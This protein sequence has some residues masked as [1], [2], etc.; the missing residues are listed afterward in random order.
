M[1]EKNTTEKKLFL[2]MIPPIIDK[3]VFVAQKGI[4]FLDIADSEQK[5]FNKGG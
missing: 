3:F 2:V 1:E 4:N 5:M